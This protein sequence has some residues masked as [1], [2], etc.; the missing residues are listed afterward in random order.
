MAYKRLTSRTLLINSLKTF[1]VMRNFL[2]AMKS[3]DGTD[4]YSATGIGWTLYD[5][6]FGSSLPADT[7]TLALNDWFVVRSA[8]EN[9]QRDMYIRL[10]MKSG[11]MDIDGF[12]SWNTSTNTGTQE[13]SMNN[14][15]TVA[16]GTN[17]YLWIYGDLDAVS[18]ILTPSPF[19][20]YYMGRFGWMPNSPISQAIT[21]STSATTA[22]VTD[23]VSFASVP[24]A[25]VAGVKLFVSDATNIEQLTIES[26]AGSDVTFTTATVASYASGSKFTM[27]RTE[28]VSG[29]IAVNYLLISH[30]GT[31]NQLVTM[32]SLSINNPTS[33]DGLTGLYP[34]GNI[35]MN[36]ATT[37]IGPLKNIFISTTLTQESDHNYG[38]VVYKAFYLHSS[39]R[40]LFL[41]A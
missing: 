13:Y 9:G 16:A 5:Y 20:S 40:V 38:G 1:V 27:E 14:S 29:A 17:N 22:G 8:G 21:L 23:T 12:L 34:L 36:S 32:E 2:C 25:W 26:V 37:W 3:S 10:T 30:N 35:Y 31:K 19:S 24:G 28:Y 11:Y 15:M 6:S 33:G 4:D 18:I 41:E 39:I 7:P